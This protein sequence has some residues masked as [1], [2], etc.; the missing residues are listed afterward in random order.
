MSTTSRT[1]E[2]APAPANGHIVCTPDTCFGKPRIDGTRIRVQDVVAWH[3]HGG[4]SVDE[5]LTQFPQLKRAEIYAALTYYYDHQ[6]EVDAQIAAD[7]AF[8]EELRAKQPSLL[9]RIRLKQ[10]S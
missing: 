5:I 8:F 6:A 2:A 4:Q 3:V 1:S 10:K 7:E 9:E